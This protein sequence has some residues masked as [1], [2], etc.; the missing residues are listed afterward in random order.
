ME[1]FRAFSWFSGAILDVE[2][3]F[4]GSWGRRLGL[5]SDAILDVEARFRG[6]LGRRA[7]RPARQRFAS[8]N[9]GPSPS[10]AARLGVQ[11]TSS[12][13]G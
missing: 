10:T 5:V 11:E 2:A 4:R 8:A 13:P 9:S 6:S 7:E 1:H 12:A 3:R